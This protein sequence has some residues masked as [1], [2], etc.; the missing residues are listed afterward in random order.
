MLSA[1]RGV[2]NGEKGEV[3]NL[4]DPGCVEYWEGRNVGMLGGKPEVL[5][6]LRCFVQSR[7]MFFFLVR[8]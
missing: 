4:L 6:M 8:E 5:W 2:G 1:R 3:T 7:V